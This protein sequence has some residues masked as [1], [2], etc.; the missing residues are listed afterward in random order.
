MSAT[1]PAPL[2]VSSVVKKFGGAFAVD[3]VSFD[4]AAGSITSLI[5]PNGAGKTTLFGVV[6]GFLRSDGGQVH[7]LGEPITRM[8]PHAIA[9]R[10]LLRTFQTTKVLTKMSVLDNVMTAARGNPG[11]RLSQVLFRPMRVRRVEAEL[12][13]RARE[14]LSRVKLHTLA[15]HYA[16]SLSGGQ[17]KLLELAMAF[18]S[19][20][21]MMLLDEPMAGVNP[22]LGLELISHVVAERDKSGMTFL[23]IEHDMNVVMSISDRVIVMHEGRVIADGTPSEIQQNQQVIDAYL[24]T[25]RGPGPST[26]I[27]V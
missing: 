8:P 2:K 6:S 21:R 4:V 12:K 7:W 27:A 14:L 25:A 20:P 9:Q 17:R 1:M 26:T 13:E 15:T 24:G 11:E 22:A 5:G 18:M 23:I 19:S 10:G 16:G 3:G